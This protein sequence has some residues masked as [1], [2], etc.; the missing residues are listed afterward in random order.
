VARMLS[1]KAHADARRAD[2]GCTIVTELRAE[3]RLVSTAN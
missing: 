3:L 2:G 1:A